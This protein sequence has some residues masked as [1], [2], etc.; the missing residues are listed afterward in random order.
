MASISSTPAGYTQDAD[1][2]GLNNRDAIPGPAPIITKLNL[3]DERW[4]SMDVIVAPESLQSARDSSKPAFA[5]AHLARE[6]RIH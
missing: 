1:G 3:R 2:D 6:G 4:E 5:G